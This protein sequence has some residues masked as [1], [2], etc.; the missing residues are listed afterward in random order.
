MT[1]DVLWM[2]MASTAAGFVDAIVGGGGLILVPALFAVYP[3]TAPASLFG[4]NKAAAIWGTGWATWQ[5]A[6]RVRMEWGCLLPAAAAAAIGSASG[7]SLV[8]FIPAQGLRKALPLVLVALL[9]YTLQRKDFGRRHEPF[10]DSAMSRRRGMFIGA[11]IGLYDGLFGPGTG[12]F[13]VFLFVRLL[14]YDFLHASAAAKLLNVATNASAVAWFAWTGH[15]WWHLALPMAVANVV[16]SVLGTR[17]ATRHGTG[18]VRVVFIWVVLALI[19]RTA[20]DGW[21]R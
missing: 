17:L 16:G 3:S 9:L 5:Y 4:T 13:F 12:S 21:L 2:L 11:A 7:A 8:T 19:V 15:V 1:L 20:W 6:R 10:E 14:R 18:F